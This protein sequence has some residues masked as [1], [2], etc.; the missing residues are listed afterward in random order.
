MYSQVA[1]KSI[2]TA[3]PQAPTGVYVHAPSDRPDSARQPSTS[4][5][6][7]RPPG[8]E[9]ASPQSPV[10]CALQVQLQIV[11]TPSPTSNSWKS[12]SRNWKCAPRPPSSRCHPSRSSRPPTSS[13][14]GL[15][16]DCKAADPDRTL[17]QA[18]HLQV[19]H[20]QG[21]LPALPAVQPRHPAARGPQ[22]QG[23]R[24]PFLQV[25]QDPQTHYSDA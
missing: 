18:P 23:P 6:R 19:R 11:S 17:E 25:L 20:H 10:V 8:R 21:Q 13:V 12:R 2:R 3:S 15:H 16:R 1:Q 24:R 5:G 7:P 4:A 14:R 22:G 9:P